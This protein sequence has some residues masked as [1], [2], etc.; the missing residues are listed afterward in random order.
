MVPMATSYITFGAKWQGE[1]EGRVLMLMYLP[2][3]K[4]KWL[5]L[6]KWLR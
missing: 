1:V 6:W 4:A 5:H 3:Y 2:D